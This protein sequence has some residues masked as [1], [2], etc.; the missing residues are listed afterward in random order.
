MEVD[1][2]NKSHNLYDPA[3]DTKFFDLVVV[4]NELH[5]SHLALSD[6]SLWD[7]RFVD[8]QTQEGQFSQITHITEQQSVGA[9]NHDD[10]VEGSRQLYIATTMCETPISVA[11]A[12]KIKEC[13]DPTWWSELMDRFVEMV[14][15]RPG[16][17]CFGGLKLRDRPD[18]MM[19]NP[20]DCEYCWQGFMAADA[21]SPSEEYCWI[22]EDA[23]VGLD[24]PSFVTEPVDHLEPEDLGPAWDES[25]AL[26]TKLGDLVALYRVVIQVDGERL[27][28]PY[29]SAARDDKRNHRP[30]RPRQQSSEQARLSKLFDTMSEVYRKGTADDVEKMWENSEFQSDSDSDASFVADDDM[31]EGYF[32]DD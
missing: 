23:L 2:P 13:C 21:S 22:L 12:R 7:P 1:H 25:T 31:D 11:N 9:S 6:E 26:Q 14:A 8:S 27:T 30:K 3:Y 32:S 24:V 28:L 19:G 20:V 18:I 10:T 17:E 29:R 5:R 4:A 15:E 16:K